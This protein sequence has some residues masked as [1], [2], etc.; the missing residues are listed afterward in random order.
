MTEDQYEK[1]QAKLRARVD[2]TPDPSEIEIPPPREPEV[3]PEIYKDVSPLLQRGFLMLPAE[4]NGVS[5][6]FKSLNQHEYELLGLIGGIQQNQS[7]TQAF[8]NL[9][10]AYGVYMID[11]LNVLDDRERSVREIARTFGE[12]TPGARSKLIRHIS[13]LNRRA[14]VAA[15]L[16][17]AYATESYS[18][19]RWAQI[20]GLDLM[21]PT[22]TG[23][24]GTEKLGLNYAQL[25]WR[26]LNYYEDLQETMEREWENA[27]FVGAC[28]AG[29]GIQKV[30]NADER[31]RTKQK[32]ALISRKDSLIRYA[33]FGDPLDGGKLKDGK[34]IIAAHTVEELSAQLQASLRGEKDWH[35]QVVE[36]YENQV[37]ERYADQE[38]KF[39]EMLEVHKEEFGNHQVV[40]NTGL[41]GLTAAEVQERMVRRKQ[42]EAQNLAQRVLYPQ[43][44]E[45]ADE[46]HHKWG[47]TG[48]D[49]T[50]TLS[51]TDRDPAEALPITRPTTPGRPFRR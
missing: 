48:S 39:Q 41:Q 32:E 51:Q 35:D 3:N 16:T 43:L 24:A 33:L 15:I 8:W 49:V 26:A 12:F 45:K 50:S 21:A 28:M 22:V 20:R 25:T 34:V 30:H 9:F 40:G 37:R 31:R 10:L 6:V 29:K 14:N 46:R 1:E 44:D 2:G 27:K 42:F 47:L 38:Q 18:R 17:E 23:I 7:P 19:Y 5:F 11:G 36:A 13:E 4:I